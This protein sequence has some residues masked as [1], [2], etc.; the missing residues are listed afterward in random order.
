MI[1]TKKAIDRRTVL[2]GI[3]A[4]VALPLLDAMVPALTAFQ[5]TAARPVNRFGAVYVPNGMM[6]RQW[7][8]AAEGSAFEFTPILKPLE[9]FRDRLLVLSGLNSTPPA[10][11]GAVGVHARAS[12][13]FLTDMPPKV[14]NGADLEAGISMDQIAAKDLGRHTQLASLELGLEST[15]SG[16]SCDNGFNCVYTSTIS[17]R[18]AAT[19]LPTE[20]DPREVFERMFGDATSTDP[21]TRRAHVQ[22]ERSIL[23]SV[24]Q[25]IARLGKQVGSGDRAKLDEYFE[26]IRDV[27]RRIQ[28]AE[29]QSA[30][31]LPVVGHPEGIPASFEEHAK[32]MYDLYGLAYQCDLTRVI[33]FMIAHEFSG[34]TY[35]EIGVPD[36]HHPISHHQNDP[37]RLAKIAKIN[38]YHA[39]LFAYFLNKL[40]STPDGDGSLLDHVM[41]VYGAG[42]SDSNAHDPKNLPILLAGGGA[43]QIKSGRHLRFSKDTPLANLHLTLL[44]RLGVHVEKLG[45]SAGELTE[46]STV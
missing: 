14:T 29:Q 16:A 13:R 15:E 22:E 44:D 27:E 46:L 35:P 26:A 1:V 34:R 2:R 8:P 24:G 19:P 31:D 30:R 25:R 36:A 4:S 28:N 45:D 11:Q 9:P 12:T 17:W 32:L 3:G 43:G 33:T 40:K 21:A 7:T 42:M 38:T 5:K 23:D 41:I 18:G 10:G 6:M 20:H 39:S 37:A